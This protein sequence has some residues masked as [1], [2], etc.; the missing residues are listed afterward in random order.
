[1]KKSWGLALLWLILLVSSCSQPAALT[2]SDAFANDP[3]IPYVTAL[4]TVVLKAMYP[5][6]WHHFGSGSGAIFSS[7]QAFV[8]SGQVGDLDNEAGI[9]LETAGASVFG[10]GSPTEIL[11]ALLAQQNDLQRATVASPLTVAG[12]P[13]ATAIAHQLAN[14]KDYLVIFTFIVVDERIILLLSTGPGNDQEAI[15]NTNQLFVDSIKI[16]TLA[17]INYIDQEITYGQ[18]VTTVVQAGELAG[19]YFNGT[20]G[21]VVDLSVVATEEE[22]DLTVSIFGSDGAPVTP[23]LFGGVTAIE[24][25]QLRETTPYFVGIE[26]LGDVAGQIQ[27]KVTLQ[28][29]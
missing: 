2:T 14:D 11:N 3:Y 7:S 9:I 27:F 1:M 18:S 26:N 8:E 13:G 20:A 17:E 23:T 29:Q 10:N 6:A 5:R 4:E 21:E 22:M 28:G 15:I 19:V 25:L 12:Y 16:Y 24:G